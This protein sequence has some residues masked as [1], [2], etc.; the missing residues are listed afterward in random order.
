MNYVVTVKETKVFES[1]RMI[2]IAHGFKITGEVPSS[3]TFYVED[4]VCVNVDLA[5]KEIRE[6]SGVKSAEKEEL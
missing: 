6:I 5:L 2:L 1:V 4:P 3:L